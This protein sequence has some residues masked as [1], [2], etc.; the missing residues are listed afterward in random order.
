MVW[1]VGKYQIWVLDLVLFYSM[2]VEDPS[3]EMQKFPWPDG[4]PAFKVPAQGL[5][6]GLGHERMRTT[7]PLGCST[8][9]LDQ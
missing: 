8:C 3:L 2:M 6:H 7:K 1:Y 4:P 9:I 5:T